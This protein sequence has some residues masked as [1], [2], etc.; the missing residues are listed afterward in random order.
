M[1]YDNGND[2]PPDS[3]HKP[4]LCLSCKKNKIKFEEITCNLN[5]LNQADE[6]TF[7]CRAFEAE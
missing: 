6:T 3:L 2:L 7:R 5:R 1:P 4:A